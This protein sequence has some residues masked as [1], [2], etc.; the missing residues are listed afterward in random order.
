MSQAA[1]TGH[2]DA[3]PPPTDQRERATSRPGRGP[4]TVAL[5]LVGLVLV[6]AAVGV[7][8]LLLVSALWQRSDTVVLT[9]PLVPADASTGTDVTV[10]S[11]C[12]G[13]ELT[14]AAVSEVTT[15]AEIRWAFERP[16]IS[17]E[18][19]DGSVVI[20]FDCPLLSLGY[21]RASTLLIEVPVGSSVDVRNTAGGVRADGLSGELSLRS[22]AGA[23]DGVGLRSPQVTADS[24]AG[25]VTLAFDAAPAAATAL[26]SAGGVTV[27]VPDDGTAYDV[28]AST[29]AGSTTI[30]VD[31]D[32]GADRSITARSSAGAVEVGFTG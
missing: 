13:V 17:S 11:D 21:L 20:D 8:T 24:E 14:E 7:T 2:G 31:T 18:A 1:A 9:S 27:L 29:S 3:A 5:V 32:P 10:T 26:S 12:G 6:L 19:R 15:T 30:T 28:D 25:G 22:E 16:A 23:V 4:A